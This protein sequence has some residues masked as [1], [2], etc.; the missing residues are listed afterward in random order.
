MP[1]IGEVARIV[2]R[3]R[4]H[5]LGRKIS[6]AYAV[7]DAIVFKDTTHTEFM[8]KMTGKRVVAGMLLLL[9][10]VDILAYIIVLH[11]ATMGKIFLVRCSLAIKV[12]S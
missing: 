8:K 7:E 2:S 11:S 9:C 4:Q 5:L 12:V 1:E 6:K 10:E 3:L